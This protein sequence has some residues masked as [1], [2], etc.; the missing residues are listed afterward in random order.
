MFHYTVLVDSWHRSLFWLVAVFITKLTVL[1]QD[2]L[3]GKYYHTV[4]ESTVVTSKIPATYNGVSYENS[5]F[6]MYSMLP[7]VS[8]INFRLLSAK[9]T[10]IFPF[11]THLVLRV[12]LLP[13]VPSTHHSYS[14]RHHSFIP[15]LNLPFLLQDWLH[16]FPGLFTDTS[17]HIHFLVFSFSL[18]HF[19][20][21]ILCG[22]LSWVM[23]AFDHMLK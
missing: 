1:E 11:L 22:R 20:N 17:E 19:F 12:S 9:H 2:H 21:F 10:L 6:V 3:T 4:Q 13:S 18:F 15:G 7:L 23:L 16:G 5:I 14:S 8:G